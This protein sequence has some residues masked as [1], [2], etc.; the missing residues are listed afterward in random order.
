MH[1]RILKDSR[2]V[3]VISPNNIYF[4]IKMKNVIEKKS[5]FMKKS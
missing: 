1:S 3:L 2:K 5:F 4:Q